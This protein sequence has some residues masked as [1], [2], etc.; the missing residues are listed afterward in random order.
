MVA[1]PHRSMMSVQ[2][3]LTLD[4]NSFETRYEFIDGY[5]YMLAGGTADHS[6]IKQNVAS[7]IR[8][9]LRGGPCRVYDSDMKVRL[10]EMRYVYPDIS[11]TCDP[12]DRGRIDIVQSPRLIVE[13]LSPSTEAKDRGK[14]FGYYRSCPTVE[15][16]TLVDTQQQSVEVYRREQYPFWQFSP[17]GPGDQIVLTSLGISFPLANVYE[18]VIFPEDISNGSSGQE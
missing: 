10:S 18:D 16:Y 5:A 3:Y 12:R 8:S 14:K 17:F 15:E 1:Q 7:L 2:E 9:Q 6:I 4:S 11:V 13:V